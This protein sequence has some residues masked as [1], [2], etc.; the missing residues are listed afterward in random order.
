QVSGSV[1]F[2]EGGSTLAT[3]PVTNGVSTAAVTLGA[4]T[5]SV[6]AAFSD[7]NGAFAASVSS[8]AVVTVQAPASTAT[9]L[10]AS[11]SNVQ[12]GTPVTLTAS[13]TA[14]GGAPSGA[15]SFL[16]G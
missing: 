9:A 10:T 4:G 2:L 14:A 1:R 8:A 12:A 15:V 11:P 13:V 6:T 3:S 16:E 5:H 7:S